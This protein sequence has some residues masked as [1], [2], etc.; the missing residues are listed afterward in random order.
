VRPALVVAAVA[1]VAFATAAA[2]GHGTASD[3][4]LRIVSPDPIDSLDPGLAAS[5]TAIEVASET[6]SPLLRFR[7]GS[8]VPEGAAALPKVSRDGRRYMFTIRRGF[9][10]SDGTPITAANYATEIGR[11]RAQGFGSVWNLLGGVTDGIVS[12]RASGRT[13]VVGLSAPDGG[14][15]ARLAEPWACPVPV[16]LP[17]DPRGAQALPA[18]GPYEVAGVSSGQSVRLVRNP[19]YPGERPRWAAEI[20]LTT[21]GTQQTDPEA[22]D[23]GQ[24]DLF[25]S[26]WAVGSPP[27]AVLQDW[28]SRYGINRGRFLAAPATA[29]IYLAM[30]NERPL[31]SGNARLRRAVALALDRPQVIRQGGFLRGRATDRLVPP[32]LP[33]AIATP[34]YPQ[35]RPDVVA[36]KKLAAGNLRGGAAVLYVANDPVALRRADA[37]QTELAQIGLTVEIQ[38]FPRPVLTTKTATRGEPFDLTLTGWVSLYSDPEDFLVRTLDGRSIGP[39]NNFDVAYFD[40]PAINSALAAAQRLPIPQRYQA[41]GRVETTVLR[42][43]APVVPLFNPYNY[44]FLSSRV[45]CYSAAGGAA[46]G[47]GL[48]DWGSFCLR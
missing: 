28:V 41:F 45:G 6:C 25:E 26:F 19:Y 5:D 29:T 21:A 34:A 11:V 22:V 16:G 7:G 14:L 17:P 43:Y 8:V 12:L 35:G 31:F 47:A 3:Q 40:A 44:L 20:D 42:D 15:L 38:S 10:F 9:R 33:G 27:D 2:G 1:M 48:P 23:A 39:Q 37:I 24:Y 46:L 4:T 18:S 36:A 30:N 13:L 32:L